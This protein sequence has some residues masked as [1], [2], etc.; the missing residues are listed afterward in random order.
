[1]SE[2]VF[3]DF[4]ILDVVLNLVNLVIYTPL[5]AQLLRNPGFWVFVCSFAEQQRRFRNLTM[6]IQSRKIPFWNGNDVSRVIQ[7]Q[8]WPHKRSHRH[9]QLWFLFR[10]EI[11]AFVIPSFL[12]KEEFVSRNRR[13]FVTVLLATVIC[14]SF[15]WA[16]LSG[17]NVKYLRAPQDRRATRSEPSNVTEHRVT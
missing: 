6:F 17:C 8:E 7:K 1:M 5:N 11:T 14:G 10:P 2:S 13:W 3:I 15:L 12:C 16:R 9:R 4:S